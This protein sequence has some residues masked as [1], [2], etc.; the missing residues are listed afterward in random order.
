[1]PIKSRLTVLFAAAFLQ[2]A[3]AIRCLPPEIRMTA[4]ELTQRL[5]KRFPRAQWPAW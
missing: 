5:D 4:A 2:R 3:P 1:M